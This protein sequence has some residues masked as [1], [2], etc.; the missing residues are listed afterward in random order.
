[1][2]RGANCKYDGGEVGR[3]KLPV[4]PFKECVANKHYQDQESERAEDA[5]RLP[6]ECQ[7]QDRWQ[8]GDT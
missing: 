8:H 2:N 7:Q 5:A 6:A 3:G 4:H 1:V